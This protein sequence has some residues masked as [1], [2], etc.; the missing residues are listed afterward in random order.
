MD[1]AFLCYHLKLPA[2]CNF[3]EQPFFRRYPRNKKD[4]RCISKHPPKGFRNKAQGCESSSYPGATS[5]KPHQPQRGCGPDCFLLPVRDACH[6]PVGV[7]KL[8]L[9][10][11]SGRLAPRNPGL[12]D[13]IPLGLAESVSAKTVALP[14]CQ[15]QHP[16]QSGVKRR[17]KIL[18]GLVLLAGIGLLWCSGRM[19][20]P[21]ARWKNTKSSTSQRAKNSPSPN[22]SRQRPPRPRTARAIF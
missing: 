3:E 7:A 9:K 16:F 1:F 22:S 20:N 5:P 15:A 11:P 14:L 19:T 4:L 13:T 17:T 2:S 8:P 6:N 12:E 10:F 18:V 21:G